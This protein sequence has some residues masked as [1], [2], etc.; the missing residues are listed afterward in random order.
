MS[1][2]TFTL[3]QNKTSVT[4]SDG[5]VQYQITVTAKV[6]A[7]TTIDP[8]YSLDQN[9]FVYS[10]TSNSSDVTFA[11]IASISDLGNL[12]NSRSAASNAGHFEY[13]DSSLVLKYPDLD[14]AINASTTVTGRVSELITAFIKFQQKF[15]GVSTSSIPLATDDS[16]VSTYST[17][18]S[19]AVAARAAAE[20][21]LAELQKAF[22]LLK[23]KNEILSSYEKWVEETKGIADDV[24]STMLALFNDFAGLTVYAD[25]AEGASQ[26]TLT[27]GDYFT[28]AKLAEVYRLSQIIGAQYTYRAAEL[29]ALTTQELSSKAS[30]D[31]KSSEITGL[32][33][34]EATA[35]SNL[36]TFCP[37]VDPSTLS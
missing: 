14:T 8:S 7:G 35:L 30:M 24:Y 21:E 33:A 32:S 31:S 22:D 19:S 13:R 28:G 29:G 26:V 3:E 2:D 4:E 34:N 16:L 5:S 10:F 1:L 9:V 15:K 25:D 11:R 23:V 20:A 12:K 37:E 18:Y 27:G 17:A 6:T 36:S